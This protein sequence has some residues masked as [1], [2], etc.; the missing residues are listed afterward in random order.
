MVTVGTW[1]CQWRELR[2]IPFGGSARGVG[3]GSSSGGGGA[4][5]YEMVQMKD[6]GEV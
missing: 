4:G 2:P 3:E 5:E 6:E 1:A